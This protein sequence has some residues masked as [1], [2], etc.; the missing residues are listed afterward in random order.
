MFFNQDSVATSLFNA[1]N[2]SYYN[3]KAAVTPATRKPVLAFVDLYSYPPD[4]AYEVSL[5][6]YKVQ[7]TQVR[8]EGLCWPFHKVKLTCGGHVA[9]LQGNSHDRLINAR[10]GYKPMGSLFCQ[11]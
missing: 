6:A 9:T 8:S 1:V 10:H 5:A 4:T 3:N 11:K 2:T 7:Y